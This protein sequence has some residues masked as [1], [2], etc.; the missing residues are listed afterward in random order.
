MVVGCGAK[1]VVRRTTVDGDRV[2]RFGLQQ[3]V[4]NPSG[5]HSHQLGPS[6]ARLG[7]ATLRRGTRASCDPAGTGRRW[8]GGGGRLRPIR[9]GDRRLVRGGAAN[10]PG[11]GGTDQ[12]HTGHASVAGRGA[13]RRGHRIRLRRQAQPAGCL[14]LDGGRDGLRPRRRTS[15]RRRAPALPSLAGDAADA[16]LPLG[17]RRGGV[18]QLGQRPPARGHGL[19]ARWRPPRHRPQARALARH[20]LLAPWPG[21]GRSTACR[22]DPFRSPS[23]APPRSTRCSRTSSRTMR[24]AP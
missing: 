12:R 13:G 2:C 22:A 6:P 15:H 4:N 7:S 14:P 21:R 11:D 19:Q 16:G 5:T 23:G 1:D 8:C 24:V 18:A 3:V 17:L 9:A 10:G 20:R